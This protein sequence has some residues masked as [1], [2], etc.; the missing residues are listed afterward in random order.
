MSSQKHAV[1]PI[2]SRIWSWEGPTC[3]GKTTLHHD[4]LTKRRLKGGGGKREC[5]GGLEKLEKRER[6]MKVVW[7]D[8]LGIEKFFLGTRKRA[9]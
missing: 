4:E 8:S 2:R 6:G 3:L 9:R 5:E 1:G 7:K